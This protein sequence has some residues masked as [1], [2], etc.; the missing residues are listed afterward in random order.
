MAGLLVTA[1]AD[2]RHGELTLE[3]APHSVVD[4][5]GFPPCLLHTVIPI[6]LVTLECLRAL[7]D[8]G[9]LDGHGGSFL[10]FG[11]RRLARPPDV[12]SLLAGRGFR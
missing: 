2:L 5:L 1:I 10:R 8:N 7:L 3:S 12:R 4:T 6:R 9:D 11:C